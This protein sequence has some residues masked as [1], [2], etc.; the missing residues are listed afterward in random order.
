VTNNAIALLIV[1]PLFAGVATTLLRGRVFLQR[2]TGLSSLLA[3]AGLI[4]LFMSKLSPEAPLLVSHM[5]RWAAPFGVAIVFDGLSGSLLLVT[6][7]VAT[8]VYVAAFSMLHERLERGW[9]H[10]LF[11]L[12]ILGVNFSFI[13]GDL[14]NLFVA[15]EIML[16]AS[17]CLMVLGASERQLSQAYKYVVLNLVG[18]TIFVLTAGLIYG[19]VGTLNYADLARIVAEHAAANTPMP[20]GFEALSLCLLFVFCLKAAVF[21]LWFWLPDTYHTIPSPL[22]ALFA[23]LLSKVGVYAILRLYPTA[24]ASPLDGER[25]VVDLAL[26]LSAGLTMVIAIV[27]ACAAHDMKRIVAMILI[28]HVGYLIFGVTL[29]SPE[30]FAATLHYMAQEMLVIAGLFVAAGTI[31]RRTQTTNIRRLGG[32][33]ARMPALA[34]FVF[35]LLMALVGIPPLSGF[36][37]K[38]VLIREGLNAGAFVLTGATV[39]T[40]GLTIVAVGRLWSRVFWSRPTGA[41]VALP[42]G[43]EL[44]RIPGPR[45]AYVA[46]GTLAACS[47]TIGLAAEPTFN[48]ARL[49]TSELA[50]PRS[51][52]TT[53]L[54]P[55]FGDAGEYAEYLTGDPQGEF[56]PPPEAFEDAARSTA[57]ARDGVPSVHTEERP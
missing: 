18:S 51:Y 23:A 15:F 11:H 7:V 38:L 50:E 40:A 57:A 10:P 36:F 9:F 41:G 21:P 54:T 49:G 24:F 12:L 13:T 4:V 34:T 56:Y 5:G 35:V 39:L 43:A 28:S 31:E 2:V 44:G 53:V 22:G 48:F 25:G 47:I 1:L 8:C 46:V 52:V 6:A 17:Y 42:P 55:P 32:L 3:M 14:F 26:V 27:A 20:P 45:G 33:Y 30:A 19:L 29:M 37:G 16:M